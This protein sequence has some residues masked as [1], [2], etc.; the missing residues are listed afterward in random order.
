[1]QGDEEREARQLPRRRA[2]EDGQTRAAKR[3]PRADVEDHA[4]LEPAASSGGADDAARVGDAAE[5]FA[6]DR[7]RVAAAVD[8][9]Q[10]SGDAAE[11]RSAGGEARAKRHA[12]ADID[13]AGRSG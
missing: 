12:E 1:D 6:R 8:R 5:V 11:A 13:A 4:G 7:E 10:A 3:G 9:G 2:G